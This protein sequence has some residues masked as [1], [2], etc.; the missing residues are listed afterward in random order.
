MES[1]TN[2]WDDFDVFSLIDFL[3]DKDGKIILKGKKDHTGFIVKLPKAKD[4]YRN[5]LPLFFACC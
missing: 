1:F 5:C 4:K 2:V 3:D